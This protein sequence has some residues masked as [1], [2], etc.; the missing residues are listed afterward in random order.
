MSA[1]ADNDSGGGFQTGASHLNL[2]KGEKHS[3]E[4]AG[5]AELRP[6]YEDGAVEPKVKPENAPFSSFLI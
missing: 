2:A 6:S 3:G 5:R 1:C 4:R